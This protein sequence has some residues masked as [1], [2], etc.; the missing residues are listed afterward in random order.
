[1]LA[2][3]VDFAYTEENIHILMYYKKRLRKHI[4]VIIYIVMVYR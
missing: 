4:V 2:Y 1:M 3:L